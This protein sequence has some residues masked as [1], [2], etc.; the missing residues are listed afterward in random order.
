[1][2]ATS[3]TPNLFTPNNEGVLPPTQPITPSSPFCINIDWFEVFTYEPKDCCDKYFYEQLGYKVVERDYGT[4]VFKEVLTLITNDG[5]P[6]IEI[7]RNPASKKSQ[8]GILEDNACSI[9]LVNR[10]CYDWFP[11]NDLYNFLVNLGFSYGKNELCCVSRADIAVDFRYDALRING[12]SVHCEEFIRRFMAGEWWKIGSA[13]VQTWGEEFS[14]GMHYNAIKFGSPTSMVNTKLYNK[15]HEMAEVKI[16]PYIVESW[17][18]SGLLEDENDQTPIWRL[19]FSIHGGAEQWVSEGVL[20]AEDKFYQANNISAW[21]NT[22]NYVKFLRGLISHYF[23]FAFKECGRS[24]YR[25]NRFVPIDVPATEKYRPIHIRP[26]RQTSGRGEK[27]LVNKL[28]KLRESG[29]FDSRFNQVLEITTQLLNDL[30]CL[31][32]VNHSDIHDAKT[33]LE[34]VEAYDAC[35]LRKAFDEVI[36]DTSL[37]LSIRHTAENCWAL[38]SRPLMQAAA[39]AKLKLPYSVTAVGL[40]NYLNMTWE[41]RRIEKLLEDRE[42][43][44][45]GRDFQDF[46]R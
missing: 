16:K 1:M 33:M 24:K 21:V 30:Y 40:S 6:W 23:R 25:C 22:A 20:P 46:F 15:T 18:N 32:A 39:R 5:Q 4:R 44:E 36:A 12:D 2:T 9:R 28:L 35:L 37:E 14:D 3:I 29:V 31:H 27:I 41:D 43:L 38:C 45:F 7:R 11:I 8:G 26:E 34:N 10:A 42:S 17:V 13:K 19:E